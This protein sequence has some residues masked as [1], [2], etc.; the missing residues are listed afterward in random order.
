VHAEI[1]N[2]ELGSV[3]PVFLTIFGIDELLDVEACSNS[4]L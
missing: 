1:V 4:I 3:E 2:K